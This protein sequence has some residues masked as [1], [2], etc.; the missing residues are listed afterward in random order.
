[1][2]SK[3]NDALGPLAVTGGQFLLDEAHLVQNVPV[4][5]MMIE[6]MIDRLRNPLHSPE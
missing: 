1:M 6:G 4:F 2:E 5:K 3:V